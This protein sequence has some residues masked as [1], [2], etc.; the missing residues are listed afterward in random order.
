MTIPAPET[1]RTGRLLSLD[2][3]RG[4]TIAG[5][6]LVNNPGSWSSIYPPLEHA[7]WHGWTPTDLIFP[8]FLFIVGV[9]MAFSFAGRQG[10]GHSRGRLAGHVLLRSA[11]LFALGM[12]LSG[13]PDYDFSHR[14]ILDVLQ[15]IGVVYCVSAL[16][17]LFTTERTQAA[18]AVLFLVVYWLLMV[19]IPVPGFG[20][21]DLTP[22][23]NVWSYVD[24]LLLDGW[25]FHAEGI[26]SLI[27][28]FSTVLL[29]HLTGQWLRTQ[30]S[31][32]EKVNVMFVVGN[33]GLV[34]GL[35]LDVWFP[36]NKLLWSSAYVVFTAGF[37]LV[38]LGVLYWM[39][40][41]RAWK[42]W[43]VPLVAFGMNAIAAFF[44]S[45]LVARILGLVTFTT[46]RADGTVVAQSLKALLY[47]TLFSSWLN[48]AS[49]SLAYAITYVLL[50]TG[51]MLVFYQKRVFIKL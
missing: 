38:V 32:N 4:L 24:R 47:N 39:I 40:E 2:A 41:I 16:L 22:E 43:S 36:I 51:V 14:L 17:V 35:V 13:L 45:S 21:G 8:F 5:M 7:A 3:F 34:A 9:A 49:A 19:L 50:W 11:A 48:G 26:L 33:V 27:P 30:R 42:T 15:R 1:P 10:K 46:T 44:L 23:G 20:R 6:I 18:L 37:A 28:S 12:V 31:D 25:H 29:G